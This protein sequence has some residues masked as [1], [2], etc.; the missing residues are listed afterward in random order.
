MD[1]AKLQEIFWSARALPA[2][3][4]EAFLAGACADDEA[5]LNQLQRMLAADATGSGLLDRAPALFTP[6]AQT[7]ATLPDERVG[8][9]IVGEELGR[10]GMGVVYRAYDPRLQRDVALKFLAAGRRDPQVQLRL[11]SE[12]RA[13]SALDHPNNCP[14]YDIGSTDDGRLY[15]AMA[16]CAGGSIAQRLSDGPLPVAEAVRIALQ[17]AHALERAHSAGI[18]HRDIKPAN[19]AFTERG[20]A[21]LLDFGMAA[22]GEDGT[23]VKGGTPAY[24]APEQVRGATV[25]GR[26]DVWALGAVLFEMLTGRKAFADGERARVMR[27]ILEDAPADIRRIRPEVP[28]ALARVVARALAKPPEQR[29]GTAAEFA[30]ALRQTRRRWAAPH[31]RL[32]IVGI[33]VAL[34]GLAGYTAR[35][36]LAPAADPGTIDANAVVV[37]PFRVSG[38]ASLAYLREGMVDLVSA[39]LTGGGG[40]RAADPRAVLARARGDSELT[41]ETGLQVARELGAGHALFGNVVR[42]ASGL[43]INGTLVNQRGRIVGRSSEEGAHEMLSTLVDRLV[44]GLL[45][46]KAGEEPQRLAS[47][48]STSLPALRAFLEGHSAF[49]RGRF[50]EA[51]DKYGEALDHDSTFALAALGLD[52]ADGWVGTGHAGERGRALAWHWRDRLSPRDRALLRVRVGDNY[53]ARATTTEKLDATEQ[54]LRLSPDRAEL[55][56]MLADLHFHYGR[57]MGTAD[58]EPRARRGFRRALELD[59]LFEPPRHH[60]I[61]LHARLR[62]LPDMQREARSALAHE[63][64]GATAEYI[65]WRLAAASGSSRDSHEALDSLSSETLAWIAMIAIDDGLS[66]QA[67]AL[68]ALRIRAARPATREQRLERI[69]SLHAA[70][71]NGG[72]PKAALALTDTLREV[73]PDSTFNLRVR[74]LAGMYGD[75]DRAAAKAAADQLSRSSRNLDRCVA[76]LWRGSRYG[77]KGIAGSVEERICSAAARGDIARLNELYRAGPLDFY[78]GSGEIDFAP[79]ALARLLEARGDNVGALAAWRQRP[80]FIGWQPFLAASLREEGRL[81]ERLGDRAGARRAYQHYLN[82]HFDPEPAMRPAVDSIRVVVARLQSTD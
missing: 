12:A 45:I 25:D 31:R 62:E 55:W 76:A 18:V 75:G 74:V 9:Y 71:L 7:T 21:R 10:G 41:Q 44:A 8:P 50:A 70:A 58:W 24:M 20:D 80:Y 56:Y 69:L 61:A 68:N 40:L 81:A 52:M 28:P 14:V 43:I 49:R 77:S 11:I 33:T 26:T 73:Q 30:T 22:Y 27:A 15:I 39:K 35:N 60:L 34:V 6:L 53:P 19:I 79:A 47:L 13:A 54:A 36:V 29:Y 63:P 59:S 17:I 46:E 32:A 38:D 82:L 23:D 65:R 66:Q 51:L 67:T 48:T 37:L 72:R 64:Q 42:T 57:A 5:A 4:R 1:W 3:E 16:Y 78:N 2:H